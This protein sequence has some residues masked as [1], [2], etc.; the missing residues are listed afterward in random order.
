MHTNV[1]VLL[2]YNKYR[3]SDCLEGRHEGLQM[4]LSET[5]GPWDIL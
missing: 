1:A 4:A 5:G 2:A 3:D